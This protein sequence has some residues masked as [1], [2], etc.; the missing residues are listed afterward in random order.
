[1]RGGK[2]ADINKIKPCAP[3]VLELGCPDSMRSEN[4]ALGNKMTPSSIQLPT[5]SAAPSVRFPM[6]PTSS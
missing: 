4:E 6:N 1:M 2:D 3:Q 5:S